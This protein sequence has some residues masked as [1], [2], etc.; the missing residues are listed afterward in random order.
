MD[1]ERHFFIAD[2]PVGYVVAFV[3]AICAAA[4]MSR[5][6]APRQ[7]GSEPKRELLRRPER[8]SAIL[9]PFAV[10]LAPKKRDGPGAAP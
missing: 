4:I 10:G 6:T 3:V 9:Q 7:R 2:V 8:A 5:A 1:Q